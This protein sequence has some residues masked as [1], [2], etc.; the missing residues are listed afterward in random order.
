MSRMSKML[1][2]YIG[3]YNSPDADI[4]IRVDMLS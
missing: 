2:P 4:C 3:I 1:N